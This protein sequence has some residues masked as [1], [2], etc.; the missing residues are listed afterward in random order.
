MF[1]NSNDHRRWVMKNSNAK[2]V[3][4]EHSKAK[5]ELYATYL[6]TYLNILSRVPFVIRI[7]IY[8]LMC[9]EGVYVDDS[10]GS[11]IIAMERI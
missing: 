6:A 4:L 10:K 2:L 11:P 8:D 5:V 3:M 7:H 9:G 1:E